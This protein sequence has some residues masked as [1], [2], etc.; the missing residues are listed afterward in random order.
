MIM[1]TALSSDYTNSELTTSPCG[2]GSPD[3]PGGP[4]GP[5]KIMMALVKVIAF[6]PL[7]SVNRLP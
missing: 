3:G 6:K 5:C 7:A 4:P 2:P 1:S